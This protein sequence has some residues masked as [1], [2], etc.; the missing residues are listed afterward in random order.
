MLTLDTTHINKIQSL[1]TLGQENF[2]L[3]EPVEPGSDSIVVS[4]V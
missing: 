1:N 4:R 3:K 2:P